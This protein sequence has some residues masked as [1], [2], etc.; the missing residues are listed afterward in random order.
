MHTYVYI[1]IYIYIYYTPEA[2]NYA[3]HG[4]IWSFPAAFSKASQTR[5]KSL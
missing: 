1:Y 2:A 4:C 3:M 5:A